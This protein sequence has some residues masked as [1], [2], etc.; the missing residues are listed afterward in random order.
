MRD[1]VTLSWLLYLETAREKVG[2]LWSCAVPVGFFALFSQRLPGGGAEWPY[3]AR[4]LSYILLSNA[5]FAF[6]MTLVWR[7]ETGF[8]RSFCLAK[9]AFARLLAASMLGS[10]VN[11]AVAVGVF[12]AIAHIL[13]PLRLTPFD[14]AAL[15]TA[16]L[17]TGALFCCAVMVLFTVRLGFRSLQ[18]TLNGLFFIAVALMYASAQP[19]L[20]W[21]QYVNPLDWGAQWIALPFT[22]P[23]S[24]TALLCGE[25]LAAGALGLVSLG[26][27]GT[28]PTQMR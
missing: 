4:F 13:S 14:M 19:G 1:I 11:S 2:Y 22:A 17:A 10:L 27:A 3:I 28:M 7:R 21:L 24:R 5:C 12:L 6:A 26:R 20:H 16:S 23:D 15:I 25:L 18:S 9:H 8:L